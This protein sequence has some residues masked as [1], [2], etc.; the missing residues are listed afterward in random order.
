MAKQTKKLG[1]GLNEM[2][3]GNVEE[4]LADIEANTP[5]DQQVHIAL[6]QIRPNPY[7]PRHYFDEDKLNE[8]AL[9]IKK[10]GVFTPVILKKSSIQG[11]EIVAGERRV[12]ASKIAGLSE[13][14]AIIVEF[15]D[16]EMM[17][18]A[19][20]ENIQRENLSAIE[21]ARAYQA[22]MEKLELTQDA[23]A[24]RIGKSRT[25]VTNMMRLLNLPESI[26]N[27]VLEGRLS[28]GHVRPL[29]TLKKEDALNIAKRALEEKLSVRE[30][31][32]LV[33]GLELRNARKP[34]DPKPKQHPYAYA[35]SLLKKKF[36]TNVKIE[37]KKVTFKFTNDDDL[38]RLLE[39]MDVIEKEEEM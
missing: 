31:E 37:D 38:N 34:K 11:Y 8:L 5:K 1:R 39:L 25:H 27:D 13:I 7:Q 6:D 22:L 36:R 12:R 20:L 26:Q 19:L 29:V 23:L 18:I 14:P 3:G 21:E 9:S 4:I 15:T 33:R 32:N 10:H 2:F 17:E 35:E 24:K 30:V 16:E 28:M